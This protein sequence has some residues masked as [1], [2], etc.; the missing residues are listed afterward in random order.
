MR[1]LIATPTYPPE[2]GYHAT[3]IKELCPIMG[4]EHHLTV[5]AYVVVAYSDIGTPS[6]EVKVLPIDKRRPLA[7]RLV[8]F[9]LKILKESRNNDLIYV[10]NTMAAGLPVALASFITGKPF[11]LKFVG[12]EAQERIAQSKLKKKNLKIFLIS[13]VQKFVLKRASKIIVMSE[14][15]RQN[16]AKTQK[17]KL[18]KIITNYNPPEKQEVL[19]FTIQNKKHQISTIGKLTNLSRVDVSIKAIAILKNKF[20]DIKL[21]IA[22]GGLE[23]ENLKK[24][25]LS[26]NLSQNVEFLGKIS[27]AEIWKIRKE[28]DINIFNSAEKMLPQRM[29]ENF[30]AQTPTIAVDT[31]EVK[32]VIEHEKTGLLVKLNDDKSLANAVERIFDD[33]ILKQNIIQNGMEALKIRFSWNSHIKI[34]NNIFKSVVKR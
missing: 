25:S 21:V 26:L 17:I 8:K 19:P 5:I 11:V 2:R 12:D 18:E 1:I 4:K 3:Y 28:S 14:C 9:F 27:R 20:P 33:N 10:Q 16:I 29:L 7:I 6:S 15:Q 13:L 31:P 30:L 34:L 24:L 32:E 22:G 23:I